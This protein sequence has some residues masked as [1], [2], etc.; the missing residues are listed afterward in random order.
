MGAPANPTAFQPAAFVGFTASCAYL[1]FMERSMV[2]PGCFESETVQEAGLQ[3]LNMQN[4]S[5]SSMSLYE[6]KKVRDSSGPFVF[7]ASAFMPHFSMLSDRMVASRRPLSIA[8]F[9]SHVL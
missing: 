3:P 9:S 8:M 5:W 2:A 7:V 4:I 1:A 6:Y